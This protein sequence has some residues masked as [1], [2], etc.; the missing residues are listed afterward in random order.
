MACAFAT[1][2]KRHAQDVA[3]QTGPSRSEAGSMSDE[4]EQPMIRSVVRGFG[5]SLPKRVMTNRE[6]ESMCRHDRR[7]DRPA[8]RHPPAPHRRRR[9]DHGV[10]RR[11]C[12]ARGA[13]SGQ[14]LTPD[15]ID[16]I[17]VATSTPGQHLSGDRGEHP[18]PARHAPW[19]RLR[20]PGGL[21]RFRL[22]VER[23]PTPISAA[24]LPARPR[25][26]RGD[27]LAH[28]RLDRPHDLRALRRRRRR[29]R[30]RGS[31]G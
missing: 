4:Q 30:A 31:R 13:R 24:A 29:D 3:C 28:P 12:G 27:L 18:E 20:R 9:R 19:L 21:H 2:Y 15:D 16:L 10:A 5:P 25:H 22:C 14:G 17:I 1:S 7:V 23:R 26:R 8:H 11:G 6:L